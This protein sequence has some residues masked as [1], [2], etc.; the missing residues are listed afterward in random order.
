MARRK[1]R[2][3]SRDNLADDRPDPE[4][5]RAALK[6]GHERYRLLMKL[7]D[8]GLV[9]VQDGFIKEGNDGLTKMCGYH[10]EEVVDTRLAGFFHADDSAAV[11][12][13][14][15]DVLKD[16]NA[17]ET[18]QAT[19][20]CKNG[21]QLRVE[22]TAA[23]CAF[24]Q[25][26][27]NTLIIRDISQRPDVGAHLKEHRQLD[28]IAAIA[29]G[30]AHDYNNLLTA[31]IGNITLAQTYLNK[32]DK[33]FRLLNHALVAS[34]TARSLT[35]KLI[36]FSRGG[37][38][39]KE[40]TAVERLVRSAVEFTLSGSNIQCDYNFAP[41]LWRIKVD[42]SQIGQA[43]HNV[44]M[45]AREAM[46]QGGHIVAAADNVNL[47]YEIPTLPA[48]NYVR[49]SITDQG[50]GI[51][52]KE[53][54]KIFEPYY[55]TKNLGNHKAMGLGLSICQSI[56]KKHAGEVA[57]TSQIGF[58][59][60]LN[61]YLPAAHGDI[62][63]RAP[64]MESE[65][66]GAIFGHGKILVM[67][68]E[69]MIRELA[70]EILHHLGYRVEFAQDGAE[71]VARYKA[72][73]NSAD[74]FDAVI[75]DLTVRGGMGGKEAIQKLKALDPNVKGIVSSGY[76]DDPGMKGFKEHGFCGVVAKPYSLEELGEKLS[77]ALKG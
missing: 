31:I 56:I 52:E 74:P 50:R 64:V 14:C 16:P 55:S 53:F 46:P 77:A 17:V 76:S 26:P 4:I 21:Y 1:T 29:G 69:E 19:L 67:D 36:T 7:A 11:E 43:L 71:A 24:R 9:V 66:T 61:I 63:A 65:S 37:S 59:T 23:L 15:N 49:I 58:G 60:T 10:M 62:P 38:P 25:Q 72:A 41:D 45:N 33:P 34:Q 48:G 40:I 8:D 70:G 12:A 30:I 5:D 75:L 20:V 35:Q 3:F 6:E 51:A 2:Q 39:N 54:D 47:T 68:D 73:L 32:D 27:A 44:V 57:V 13:L 18:L 22:I 28:S 42:Q